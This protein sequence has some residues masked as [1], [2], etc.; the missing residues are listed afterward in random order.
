MEEEV[1]VGSSK[2]CDS[3]VE[4]MGAWVGGGWGWGVVIVSIDVRYCVIYV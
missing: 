1:G 2:M 3:G 4:R